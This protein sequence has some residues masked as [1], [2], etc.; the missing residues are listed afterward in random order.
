MVPLYLRRDAVEANMIS[1]EQHLE[2]AI[3]I[4]SLELHGAQTAEESRAALDK[5][6]S[7]IDQRTPER[8]AEMERMRG[9]R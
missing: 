1:P 5:L 9:I 6:K 4:A 2:F 3:E 7:L 8:V